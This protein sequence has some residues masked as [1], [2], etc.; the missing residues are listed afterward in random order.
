MKIATIIPAAPGFV[1]YDTSKKWEF[2]IVAWGFTHDGALPIPIT[3]LG[4][5]VRKGNRMS[6]PSDN[7]V[8]L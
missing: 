5:Q 2:D 6:T 7:W 4:P 3:V 8:D 1:F